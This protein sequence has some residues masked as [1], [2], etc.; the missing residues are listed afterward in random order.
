MFEEPQGGHA[1]GANVRD[2]AC[3]ICWALAR[4]FRPSD[5]APYVDQIAVCLTCVA[6]F[7]REI[8]V[9]RLIFIASNILM[10]YLLCLL[11][12]MNRANKF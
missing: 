1:L 12:I 7:D 6:I 4:T 10:N 9:R 11:H 5:L 8:N 2:A 3:Y